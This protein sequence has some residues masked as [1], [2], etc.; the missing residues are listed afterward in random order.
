VA[1]VE[2]VADAGGA[3]F[4]VRAAPGAPRSA[5]RGEHGGALKVAIAAPPEKGK[6]NEELVRLL[7][8]ALDVDRRAVEV[9]AGEASKDKRVRIAGL[10]AGVL[11]ARLSSILTS[12]FEDK[13]R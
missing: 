3:S 1:P 11:Q 7:A 2:V 5:V 12:N 4:R 8:R 10:D 6:A 13:K 9:V